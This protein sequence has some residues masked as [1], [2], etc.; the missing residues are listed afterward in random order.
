MIKRGAGGGGDGWGRSICAF[1]QWE[2]AVHVP[3]IIFS[4]LSMIQGKL[5]D[6]SVLLLR[7]FCHAGQMLGLVL[8]TTTCFI[9]SMADKGIADQLAHGARHSTGVFVILAFPTSDGEGLHQ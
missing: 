5:S 3:R 6:S 8:L 2:C 4:S 7:L 9:A 1:K